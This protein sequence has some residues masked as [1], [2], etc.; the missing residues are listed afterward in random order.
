MI[1]LIQILF[2]ALLAGF[3]S[4]EQAVADFGHSTLAAKTTIPSEGGVI[5]QFEQA[6]DQTT[7]A[8]SQGML[9]RAN[10]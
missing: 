9:R 1:R 2:I 10:G 8:F 5:R 7:I 3:G 6:A 4:T